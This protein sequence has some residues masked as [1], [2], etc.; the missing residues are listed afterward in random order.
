MNFESFYTESFLSLSMKSLD[1]DVFVFQ[2]G[3]PPQLNPAIKM[4]I[5]Q[6][7]AQI[8]AIIPLNKVYII[9]SIL[10]KNYRKDSDIDVTIEVNKEDLDPDTGKVIPDKMVSLLR[11]LN[12]KMA[13]GTTHPVNYFITTEFKEENADAIYD[14]ESDKWL[15]E[16][17]VKDLDIENYINKFN[18]L[19]GSVD[20]KTGQLRRDLIDYNELK[21]M[22]EYSLINVHS[23]LNKK[24]YEINK[25]IE[26][27]INFKDVL[28][29][30]R[31][32]V[33]DRPMSPKEIILFSSKNKLPANVIYKLFQKY[34]YFDLINN[35]EN[36]I[37]NRDKNN[38][39]V[40]D[41]QDLLSY[42]ESVSFQKYI[43]IDEKIKKFK[44][45]SVNWSDPKSI[46]KYKDRRFRMSTPQGKKLSS[47]PDIHGLHGSH[48]NLGLSK[49]VVDVAKRS[50]SGIW[51]LTPIQVKEIAMKYHHI[52]PNEHDPIKHLGNTGIVVWRKGPDKFYLVKHRKFK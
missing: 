36:V 17:S 33:F 14:L 16:P 13:V 34:Y 19:V 25:N 23:L 51:R 22:D 41:I 29:T 45:G 6:D 12:G 39:Y 9:G 49:K 47:V 24:L 4:Q 28:K 5:F 38:E 11:S 30:K 31:K 48:R 27:L 37:Q 50:P 52:P 35:L 15:K 21:Q 2:E 18:D 40:K 42:K 43:L 10:T 26:Y 3:L 44:A 20:L 8:K 32:E 7:V 46:R 1:P